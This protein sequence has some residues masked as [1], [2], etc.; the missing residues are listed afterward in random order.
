MS[1]EWLL[2]HEPAVRS[3]LFFALLVTLAAIERLLPFRHDG[4]PAR[5]QA[6]NLAL[7]A[8]DATL[9]R[10]VPALLAVAWAE[11]MQAAGIGLL[12]AVGCPPVIAVALGMLGLDLTI[13]LQHRLM[14]RVPGLWRLHRVHHSDVAFDVTLG[15]RFH[16]GEVVL[17]QGIKLAA[18]TV[19]G[20][21]PLATLLFEISLQ[22]SALFTHTDVAL[23]AAL[24]RVLRRL[25]VTPSMHRIHHSTAMDERN[26]NFG[27]NFVWWDR[28]FATYRAESRRPQ[29]TMPIGL[30]DFRSPSEQGLGALLLQPLRLASAAARATLETP[31]A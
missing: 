19:L 27:F 24:D 14:H 8:L 15:V 21:P 29:Q 25:I 1:G 31:N 20:A 12:P 11:R 10:A 28:L 7:V 13:Y 17:S 26:D 3:G 5:R 9:L 18:V 6:V 2:A 16:P 22:G 30:D 4:R 23:P